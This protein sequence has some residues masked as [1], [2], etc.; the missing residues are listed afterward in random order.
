MGD[1]SLEGMENM[2]VGGMVFVHAESQGFLGI[3]YGSWL[4]ISWLS[5][6]GSE[7]HSV[8]SKNAATGLR[9]A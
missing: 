5:K 6:N 4:E 8:E 9:N 2:G 3:P 1:G 7:V